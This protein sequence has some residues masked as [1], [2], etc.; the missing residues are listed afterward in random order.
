MLNNTIEKI[1]T[2]MQDELSAHEGE[3]FKV[4]DRDGKVNI[5]AS[6]GI[7]GKPVDID[8]TL[9]LSYTLEKRTIT[10]EE[11]V[12]EVQRDLFPQGAQVK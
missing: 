8:L 5:S 4:L 2:V 3:I 6:I 7:E 9:K 10:R 12:S 1:S 11:K